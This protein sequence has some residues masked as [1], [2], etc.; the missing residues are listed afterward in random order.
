MGIN[1]IL[2][3]K[4]ARVGDSWRERYRVFMLHTPKYT[5]HYPFL[6]TPDNWPRWIGRDK[7]A[8]FLEHYS[9]IMDLNVQLKTT[10]TKVEYEADKRRYRVEIEGPDGAKNILTPRHVVLAA[11]LFSKKPV[12]PDIPGKDLFRGQLYHSLS[13]DSASDIADL[14]NKNVVIIGS[15]P[16]GHD[17]AFDFVTNNARS[18]SLVQRSPTFSLSAD[19]VEQTLLA[20]WNTPGVALEDADVIGNSLP[21][22]VVRALSVPLSHMMCARDRDMIDRLKAA[23]LAVRTGENGV[24]LAEFQLIRGGKFYVDQGANQMIID[25][26]IKILRSEGGVREFTGRGVVLADRREVD[27]DVVV[28]ATG[29]QRALLIVREIMGDAVAEKVG[30]LQFMDVDEEQERKGVSTFLPTYQ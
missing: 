23:R 1:T 28:L 13:H 22:A 20:G 18:V 25:G 2:V 7:V 12:L 9:Q 19:T 16:S 8:D 10:V 21:T 11:G 30:G 6:K 17:L 3:D 4:S 26:R 24:G 29:Q 14:P 15:G 27:A 5:D